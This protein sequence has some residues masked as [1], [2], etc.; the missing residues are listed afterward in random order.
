MSQS[1]RNQ[2][3]G[4]T[5]TVIHCMSPDPVLTQLF[6][7]FV[8]TPNEVERIQL[9]ATRE[10]RVSNLMIQLLSKSDA[11]FEAL[12]D[13]L[14]ETEQDYVADII[15]QAGGLHQRELDGLYSS[16]F[17]ERC[18]NSISNLSNLSIQLIVRRIVFSIKF[19]AHICSNDTL[20]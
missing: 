15:L 17:M 20:R 18:K 12:T 4:A 3:Q 10:D 11:A 7:K 9:N 14:K 2:L 1:H 13:A 8:L 19:N 5:G 6:S 16:D